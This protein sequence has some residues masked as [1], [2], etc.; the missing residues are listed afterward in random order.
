MD[1]N[2]CVID[3]NPSQK[4][5][6]FR[7]L[8]LGR[9]Y[10]FKR[11]DGAV[12]SGLFSKEDMH[13][14][15]LTEMYEDSK[16]LELSGT[17][18]FD[19]EGWSVSLDYGA[20]RRFRRFFRESIR[21]MLRKSQSVQCGEGSAHFTLTSSTYPKQMVGWFTGCGSCIQLD[22]PEEPSPIHMNTASLEDFMWYQTT[23]EVVAIGDFK[24]QLDFNESIR[25][26]YFGHLEKLLRNT[27]PWGE[28]FDGIH[29][30]C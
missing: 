27:Q 15:S 22:I 16:P 14:L 13:R 2:L 3:C 23:T 6:P 5:I 17:S 1:G 18:T 9:G 24:Y 7:L 19:G 26:I 12:F 21:D 25:S 29:W 4:E 8:Y 20:I 30:P 11:S 10:A 28:H